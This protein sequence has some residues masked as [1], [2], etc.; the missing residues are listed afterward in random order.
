[1]RTYC[2]KKYLSVPRDNFTISCIDYIGE[3]DHGEEEKELK[4][5]GV[6][7]KLFE[8]YR[9][10]YSCRGKITLTADLLGDCNRCGTTQ[11]LD[12]CKMM[13]SA[14]M[15]LE[16]NGILRS[17][18]GF[19]PIL[20]ERCGGDPSKEALLSCELFNLVYSEKNVIT[21]VSR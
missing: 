7:V 4:M 9:G 5:T 19:S 21:H 1:M 8:A 3:I 16:A 11:R 18:I 12:R 2:N 14:R 13:A 20:E 17:L 6:G 10:C 15:D